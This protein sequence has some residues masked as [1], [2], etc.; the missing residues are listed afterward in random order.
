MNQYQPYQ[1]PFLPPGTPTERVHPQSPVANGSD[2]P[3]CHEALE[4][5]RCPD[6]LEE[7][8]RLEKADDDMDRERGGL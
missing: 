1:D 5:C 6:D 2:C 3:E 8:R 4:D 7:Q